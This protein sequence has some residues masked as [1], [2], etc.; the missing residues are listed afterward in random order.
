MMA[1]VL[2]LLTV[3]LFMITMLFLNAKKSPLVLHAREPLPCGAIPTRFVMEEPECTDT[4][5]RLMNGTNV[6]VVPVAAGESTELPYLS[7]AI[8][9]S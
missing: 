4:L 2:V 3:D 8:K 6:H 5:L 1:C 9:S 7:N